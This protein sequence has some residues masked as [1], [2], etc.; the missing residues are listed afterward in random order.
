MYWLVAASQSLP[1]SWPPNTR[2]SI[3]A[4]A[5]A[6]DNFNAQPTQW[7]LTASPSPL[8]PDGRSVDIDALVQVINRCVATPS[9]ETLNP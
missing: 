8:C 7:F 9:N 1:P 5:P 2:T 6:T 3:N 4:R